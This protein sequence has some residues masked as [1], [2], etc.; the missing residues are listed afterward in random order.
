MAGESTY[1]YQKTVTTYAI[2]KGG[3]QIVSQLGGTVCQT[4]DHA[5]TAGVSVADTTL[6]LLK[7]AAGTYARVTYATLKTLL[8]SSLSFLTKAAADLLYVPLSHLSSHPAPTSR[9]TRNEAADSAI[10]AHI[11][12]T[13]SPHTAAG[14]G[15]DASG[16]AATLD[17][18]H[19]TAYEHGPHTVYDHGTKSGTASASIDYSATGLVQQI[20][21]AASVDLTISKGTGWPAA[22]EAILYLYLVNA[23]GANS[24]TWS[25]VNEWDDDSALAVGDLQSAGVDL[26]ILHIVGGTITAKKAYGW[27]S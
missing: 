26:I 27:A 2:N 1:T 5:E 12:G 18:A 7:T 8:T 4:H 13:G 15:A 6:F 22:D 11:T 10:Q 24:I 9:D 14:V 21:C 20:T 25:V 3:S 17:A 16:T 19:L 23:G